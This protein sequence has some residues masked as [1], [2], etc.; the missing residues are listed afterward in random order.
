MRRMIGAAVV[1]MV[2]G[3]ATVGFPLAGLYQSYGVPTE[4]WQ[5]ASHLTASALV[6]PGQEAGYPCPPVVTEGPPVR[7]LPES[8]VSA[9]PAV[10]AAV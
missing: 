6:P 5:Q 7:H 2:L 3:W 8:S 10:G 9:R 4:D 1:L